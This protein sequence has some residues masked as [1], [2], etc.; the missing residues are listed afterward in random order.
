MTLQASGQIRFSELASEFGDTAPINFSSFYKGGV[1]VPN[2]AANTNVPTSGQIKLSN[3]YSAS[4][5][6]APSVVVPA[7]FNQI[8]FNQFV[9]P[10]NVTTTL[11]VTF[12]T[13]GNIVTSG[14]NFDSGTVGDK[15]DW[16]S[17][18][19]G[20]PGNAGDYEIFASLTSN[21][22]PGGGGGVSGST[23]GTFGSWQ[24]FSTNRAWTA[25]A[26]SGDDD[27]WTSVIQFQIREI[28]N[29]AN[30]DTINITL[31]INFVNTL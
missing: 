20:L 8:I 21:G 17:D 11:T 25:S 14:S 1:L 2:T 10:P 30:T 9:P 6:S 29:T 24:A 27:T 5:V 31:T 13:D 19:S 15:G 23:S 26:T 18:I 28:A 12:Q 22:F 16:L 7:D 3:F 4:V